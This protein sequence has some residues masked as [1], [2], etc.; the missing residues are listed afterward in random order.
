MIEQQDVFWLQIR[1]NEV[2][3]VQESNAAQ[4][5]TGESLNVRS[6]KRYKAALLE[7]VKDRQTEEGRYYAYMT[8]PVEAI[9]ELDASIP[10]GFICGA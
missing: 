10:V 3:I 2:Q 8:S 9:P 7:K 1:V 6:W 5:L 4:E